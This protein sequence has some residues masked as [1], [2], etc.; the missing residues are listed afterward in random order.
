MR[1]LK[2]F[3]M[4]TYEECLINLS[5]IVD[6][7]IYA[8]DTE[9]LVKI[10]NLRALVHIYF[11]RYS[12]AIK[13]FKQVRVVAEELESPEEKMCAYENLGRCYSYMKQYEN[14][15][16]CYKKQLEL[17]WRIGDTLFELRSYEGLGLQF[18][19]QGELEKSKFYN[20][21]FMRGKCEKQNS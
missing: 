17:A 1:A 15:I 18:F 11:E 3:K 2:C 10:F 12:E 6:A 13:D 16:K 20:D 21:R 4:R 5:E 14:A 19:Y 8:F 9:T 7:A